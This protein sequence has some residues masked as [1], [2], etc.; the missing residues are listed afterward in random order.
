MLALIICAGCEKY[1]DTLPEKLIFVEDTEN[2]GLPIVSEWG[3]NYFGAYY[4]QNDVKMVFKGS[5]FQN[6]ISEKNYELI[7]EGGITDGN[8]HNSCTLNIVLKNVATGDIVDDL[9]RK[10]FDLSDANACSV[11]IDY[12]NVTVKEG[13]IKFNRV[14]NVVMNGVVSSKKLYCGE[15][16]MTATDSIGKEIRFEKGR[17]DRMY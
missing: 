15:F 13:K 17:F 6:V 4:Y 2:P 12:N 10:E 16:N 11:K 7:F 8:E 5:D 1:E 9:N 3:H 14:N